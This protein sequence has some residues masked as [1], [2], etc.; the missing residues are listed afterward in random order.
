MDNSKLAE[1]LEY[2]S[3]LM[4]D[5]NDSQEIKDEYVAIQKQ[6]FPN[7]EDSKKKLQEHFK[8][9]PLKPIQETP[10]FAKKMG[11]I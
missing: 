7:Y 8:K 4:E 10:D 11:F 2:L 3:E 5:G 1:R 6:L 9:N